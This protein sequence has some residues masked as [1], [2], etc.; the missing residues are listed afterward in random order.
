[1]E[2]FFSLFWFQMKI[3]KQLYLNFKKAQ[4]LPV[5][6]LPIKITEENQSHQRTKQRMTLTDEKEWPQPGTTL[7][8][9]T[10]LQVGSSTGAGFTPKGLAPR[11]GMAFKSTSLECFSR[12]A[13]ILEN[14]VTRMWFQQNWRNSCL[15]ISTLALHIPSFIHWSGVLTKGPLYV[16]VM[17][18]IHLGNF[19]GHLLLF[20]LLLTSQQ[21]RSVDP[22]LLKSPG[23]SDSPL[24]L[25]PGWPILL[26]FVVLLFYSIHSWAS[27]AHTLSL[28]SFFS[29]DLSITTIRFPSRIAPLS[30]RLTFSY[31][32][33]ISIWVF[34]RYLQ[35]N[36]SPQQN[37]WF[38]KLALSIKTNPQQNLLPQAFL[39]FS[40]VAKAKM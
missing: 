40:E 27:V 2:C 34:N 4:N 29:M 37:S 38:S 13:R 33:K 11:E 14:F 23:L 17:N 8:L 3:F 28:F 31:W 22:C 16:K 7:L 9:H 39:S 32:P 15:N 20:L 35:H 10:Y 5:S 18:N 21:P 1:M 36:L 25:L 30:S 12:E 6:F 24:L 26:A 19:N